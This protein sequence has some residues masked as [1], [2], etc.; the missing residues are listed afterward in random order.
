MTNYDAAT[1]LPSNFI[2]CVAKDETG[3]VFA[4]D[5]EGAIARFSGGHWEIVR[6][7]SGH[8]DAIRAMAAADGA[9]WIGTGAGGLLRYKNGRTRRVTGRCRGSEAADP[10][11][12]P[13]PLN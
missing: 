9:L 4:G 5:W 6:K 10:A 13:R 2:R 7:S 12:A 11:Q 3:A 8:A 1:G